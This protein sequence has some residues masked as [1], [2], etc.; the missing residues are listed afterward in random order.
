[1]FK[2][3]LKVALGDLFKNPKSFGSRI[4]IVGV[5][6]V[7]KLVELGQIWGTKRVWMAI[8]VSDAD[9]FIIFTAE[10]VSIQTFQ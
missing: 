8:S 9:I 6:A 2:F 4:N 5:M 1:M 3:G 7:Q 10:I